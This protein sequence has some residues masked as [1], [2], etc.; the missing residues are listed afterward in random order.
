MKK[1]MRKVK[2][3]PKP[4]KQTVWRFILC[5]PKLSLFCAIVATAFNLIASVSRTC[6]SRLGLGHCNSFA[7]KPDP[8]YPV[9]FCCTCELVAYVNSKWSRVNVFKHELLIAIEQVK[10]FSP[11]LYFICCARCGVM[12]SWRDS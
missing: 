9:I 11:N 10:Q 12:V 3:Q 1:V 6:C 2:M 8:G 4:S 5:V 7:P